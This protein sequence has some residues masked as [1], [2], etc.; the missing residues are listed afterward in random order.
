MNLIRR[1]FAVLAVLSLNTL[2]HAEEAPI[3]RAKFE[4]TAQQVKDFATGVEILPPVEGHYY[5][6]VQGT[7][8]KKE[9]PAFTFTNNGFYAQAQYE[10]P[11]YYTAAGNWHVFGVLD[12]TTEASSVGGPF[13]VSLLA[14]GTANGVGTLRDIGGKGVRMGVNAGGSYGGTGSD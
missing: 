2:L 11:P 9:G 10:N 12:Q 4:F 3:I 13:A 5:Q 1:V 14:S 6:I 8:L 7:W